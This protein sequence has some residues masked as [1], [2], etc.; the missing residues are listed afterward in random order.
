[1]QPGP[2]S[3]RRHETGIH[4]GKPFV[5]GLPSR[6]VLLAPLE[7]G[8]DRPDDGFFGK[9]YKRK[10]LTFFRI[11]G[12]LMVNWS[13]LSTKEVIKKGCLDPYENR[14]NSLSYLI[15]SIVGGGSHE[16]QNYSHNVCSPVSGGFHRHGR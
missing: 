9:Y 4:L 8:S 10:N 6:M 12:I 13:I 3:V 7:R 14:L 2:A 15:N 5:H 1:M 11:L 16:E